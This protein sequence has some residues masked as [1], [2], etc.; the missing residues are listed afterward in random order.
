MVRLRHCSV[1][2]LLAVG[3]VAC[4]SS[5]EARVLRVG[6]S[7]H[8]PFVMR[9]R[10]VYSGISVH[11]WQDVSTG[12]NQPF[13]WVFQP[14]TESNLKALAA[15]EI[16]LA[17][18]PISITSQ[19]L[20]NPKIDF[21]QPYFQA[22]EGLL[23]PITGP[24]LLTRL[25][26]FFGLAALSS[27]GV[28]LV[29]LFVV[30]NLVWLAE[31]RRNCEQFPR[32]YLHGVGNGMWFALVTLT[33]VGYGDRAPQSRTGRAIAGV[34]MVLSLV[35]LS[36]ITAG[37]AS[38][39]TVSLA[40]RSSS[41]IEDVGDL[42]DSPVA[43][44]KGTSS[45]ALARFYGARSNVVPSLDAAVEQLS[46]HE[47]RAVMFDSVQLRYYLSRHPELP[48][49]LARVRL[50]QDAYGFALPVGSP[51]R[52]PIDVQLVEMLR[53]GRIKALTDQ[54]LR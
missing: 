12:L 49:K 10:S 11:I 2:L 41:A 43:V 32:A 54:A 46:R 23:V 15:G 51:L 24:S 20:A 50:A 44:V 8:P 39:F 35:A 36:S 6:V 28:L 31:R 47:V 40:Q 21:T 53:S 19:R 42:R 52:T 27:V 7:G 22:E 1:L 25:R 9:D 33:T 16:D 17:V 48:L 45:E 4:P 37:L 29:L 34:W 5:A 38:A 30:G 18:G 26:P 3:V 14:N 13:Q